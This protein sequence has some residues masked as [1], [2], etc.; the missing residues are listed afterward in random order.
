VNKRYAAQQAALPSGDM[1]AVTIPTNRSAALVV[2]A[3]CR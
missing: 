1:V 3:L 2:S